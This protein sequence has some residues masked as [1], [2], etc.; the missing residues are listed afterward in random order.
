[1]ESQEDAKLSQILY[2]Q[3]LHQQQ[4]QSPRQQSLRSQHSHLQ[5]PVRVENSL[6]NLSAGSSQISESSLSRPPPPAQVAGWIHRSGSSEFSGAGSEIRATQCNDLTVQDVIHEEYETRSQTSLLDSESVYLPVDTRPMTAPAVSNSSPI[7]NF[8]H[9][10]R[11]ENRPATS[12]DNRY[13]AYDRRVVKPSNQSKPNFQ[14]SPPQ[15]SGNEPAL[16]TKRSTPPI[17]Q[18]QDYDTSQEVS[19]IEDIIAPPLPFDEQVPV[20]EVASIKDKVEKRTKKSSGSLKRTSSSEKSRP[21]SSSKRTIAKTTDSSSAKNSAIPVSRSTNLYRTQSDYIPGRYAHNARKTGEGEKSETKSKS[22]TRETRNSVRDSGFLSRPVSDA[23][24][25]EYTP[26][27]HRAAV[28][29]QKRWRGHW[30]R[31]YNP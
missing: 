27:E 17:A 9:M 8:Q 18:A 14:V 12:A 4:L 16:M 24:L 26:E 7:A 3:K 2:K 29:I 22:R 1:M 10:L 21:S 11:R 20:E 13:E 5:S 23:V 19:Q 6:N 25:E 28:V 30:T 15:Q 31:Q